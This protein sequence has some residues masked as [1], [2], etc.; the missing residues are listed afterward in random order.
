MTNNNLELNDVDILLENVWVDAGTDD[1]I[2]GYTLQWIDQRDLQMAPRLKVSHPA[3]MYSSRTDA[4]KALIS[5]M[6]QETEFWAE[7]HSWEYCR[8]EYGPNCI[9]L[10]VAGHVVVTGQLIANCQNLE[11]EG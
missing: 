11:G 7:F 5:G 10:I 1:L 6:G 9:S 4:V 8:W 3:R 2:V